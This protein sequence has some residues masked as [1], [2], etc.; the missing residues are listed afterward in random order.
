[1]GMKR[2]VGKWGE[3]LTTAGSNERFFCVNESY[4]Q[5]WNEGSDKEGEKKAMRKKKLLKIKELLNVI[6]YPRWDFEA[7]FS[8]KN[9]NVWIKYGA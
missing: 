8:W 9:N 7:E 5:V 1:M 4:I 2:R 3:W 6:C